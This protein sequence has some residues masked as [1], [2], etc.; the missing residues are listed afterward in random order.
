MPDDGTEVARPEGRKSRPRTAGWIRFLR[1]CV[2]ATFFIFVLVAALGA[3]LLSFGSKGIGL[4]VWAVAEME[5]RL[6]QSLAK[7]SPLVLSVGGISVALD[8]AFAPR[9]LLSDLR[10]LRPAGDTFLT[11][12][13]ANISLD[14][15]ALLQG[16]IQP[17]RLSLVGASASLRRDRDGRFDLD[18]G[19]GAGT[20]VDSFPA[21]LDAVDAAFALPAL[22][23]LDRIDAEAMTLTLE[24]AKLG[25]TWQVGDGRLTLANRPTEVAIQLGMTLVS[26]GAAPSQAELT[27]ISQKAGPEA[28][29]S[30]TVDQVAASDLAAQTAPLGFLAVLDAPI[31]GQL[32]ASVDGQ[33]RVGTIDSRL[34]IGAGALRPTPESKPVA[35]DKAGLYLRY[36]NASE[37]L[38]LDEITVEGRSLR[39]KARGQVLMP[40]SAKGAPEAFVTQ[41]TFD[42]VSIDPEGLF[43]EPVRFSA[44][45]LDVRLRLDPFVLDVGQLALI[46]D[47]RRLR[48]KGR[49]AADASGWQVAVDLGLNEITHQKMMAL[50][51]V[52]LVPR[53]RD[54]LVENVQDSLLF[55]VQAALRLAPEQSP[56]LSLNYEFE[57]TDVRFIK[58]LPPIRQGKGYAT[59]EGNTYTMVLDRGRVT[60]PK[61]GDINMAG[62]VFTVLDI[63]QRPAQAEVRLKADSSLTATLSL[64]DEKPFGFLTRAGRPVDLGQGRAVTEALLRLPLVPKINLKDIRYEVTGTLLDVQSAMLVPG[65]VVTADRL[66][67]LADPS[68]MTISGPGKIGAVAFD[69]TFRQGFQPDDKGISTITG[70]AEISP[71]A[72]TEFN[73]GLPDGTVTGQGLAQ[74]DIALRRGEDPVLTL[75]SDLAGVGLAMPELG[76]TKP[77]TAKGDLQISARLGKPGSVDKISLQASGLQLE[78]AVSLRD[79]GGL[80][81]ASINRLVL[82][83]WLDVSV[84]LTGKGGGRAPDIAV[85][86]GRLDTRRMTFGTRKGAPAGASDLP[87]QLDRLV[88]SEGISLT[89]FAGTF[90]PAG[91]FR[92]SFT[93]RV[94]GAAA[95]RGGV[96]PVPNGTGV[97]ILADDAGAVLAAANIFGD[98][99]GGSLDMQIL[100][101]GPKGQFSGRAEARSLR[102]TN[103]PVLAEL[104]NAI[105]VIGLLEQMDQSGLLFNR[106]D[107]EFRLTPDAIE[108][109]RAAAVGASL[110]VSMAGVYVSE[111]KRLRMQ[112]VISPI[113][114][115]NGIG[116]LFSRPGEGLFGFNYQLGGTTDDPSVSVNPLSILTP[117]MFREIFR[118]PAPV[119]TRPEG[120]G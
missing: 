86:G 82:D 79:G 114:L 69:A 25:R 74:V 2:A 11:L 89:D 80:D 23:G 1:G 56:R 30:V 68:G 83:D 49:I 78:G 119:L 26:G 15:A 93:A 34:T 73:L 6:N 31:S 100:P 36:D 113:Y 92:G 71:A 7:A 46:E 64:L 8:D 27:L 87:V 43:E 24:D 45:A 40:G 52:G 42:E 112:G 85:T 38:S 81:V 53:T 62:S 101:D 21:L 84:R 103:A 95:V 50:W 47:G 105:S 107:A 16:A 32:T 28:R 54:W 59:I 77:A 91:G 17:R 96:A 65:R 51:P 120:S 110:G 116:A 117:G 29:I 63:T 90:Q 94:N 72:V 60:P 4:P 13:E 75:T 19:N 98:A 39:L 5:D 97:R 22:A 104:L 37:R 44:G 115:V 33:G 41:I 12:P 35:F 58:T 55:D 14:A 109:T 76:W 57:G 18:F 106:A 111:G 118:Q 99:R 88:V 102:V 10:L 70:T 3:G 108:L 61:G 9:L 66:N 48:A 20:E 67:L